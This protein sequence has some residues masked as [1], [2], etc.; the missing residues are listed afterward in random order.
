MPFYAFQ[1]HLEQ[2]DCPDYTFYWLLRAFFVGKC[3][4]GGKTRRP[5]GNFCINCGAPYD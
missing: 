3:N 2:N 1:Y 4:R 5:G